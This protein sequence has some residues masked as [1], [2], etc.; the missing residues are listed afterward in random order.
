[1][2]LPHKN[3]KVDNNTDRENVARRIVINV[4]SRKI[5]GSRKEERI[6]NYSG[7]HSA[8]ECGRYK[9]CGKTGSDEN[10]SVSKTRSDKSNSTRK[11]GSDEGDSTR[12]TGSDENS[13]VGKTGSNDNGSAGKTGPRNNGSA[14]DQAKAE[15]GIAISAIST[16]I[17][18]AFIA[19]IPTNETQAWLLAG[20]SFPVFEFIT[21]L[22]SK[23]RQVS[24][25]GEVCTMEL[26]LSSSPVSS[27]PNP[28]RLPRDLKAR[29]WGCPGR[30]C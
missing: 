2:V 7:S 24:R 14:R 13:S 17:L 11:T 18:T 29:A 23:A 28:P 9:T 10:D 12:K 19:F 6:Q 3:R 22:Q 21:S 5:K 27:T 1:M 26:G 4:G 25:A 30:A 8:K 15:L 20:M 16:I